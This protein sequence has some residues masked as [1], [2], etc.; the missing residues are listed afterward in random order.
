MS[1]TAFRLA[2]AHIQSLTDQIQEASSLNSL[3]ESLQ[4]AHSQ[5]DSLITYGLMDHDDVREAYHRFHQAAKQAQDRLQL[6]QQAQ[7]FSEEAN[8]TSCECVHQRRY[9]G[10]FYNSVELIHCLACKG[11]QSIRRVIL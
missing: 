1:V 5:V 9:T 3:Q 8:P 11:W 6:L 2:A 4:H 7:T 10:V